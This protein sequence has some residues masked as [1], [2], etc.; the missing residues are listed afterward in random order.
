M[1]PH[2]KIILAYLSLTLVFTYPLAFNFTTAIPGD[3]YDGWQNYWNLWWVR[4]ALLDLHTTPFFTHDLFYP[5]GTSL[6]FHTLNIFNGLWTLPLQAWGNL[7][8]TYNSVVIFSFVLS[9]YGAYLLSAHVL[10]QLRE[11]GQAFYPLSLIPFTAG[12]IFAFAPFRFAHLLGHMQVFSTEWLPFF[13]LS[14]LQMQQRRGPLWRRA[15]LPS[16]FLALTALCDWY[17]ALY[18][19]LFCAIIVAY[20]LVSAIRSTL[21]VPNSITHYLLPITNFIAV[22]CWFILLVS[23]ILVPMLPEGTTAAYLR[24]PFEESVVLSADLLAFITPSEFHPLWGEAMREFSERFTTSTAERTVFAGFVPLLLMV[25]GVWR[26]WHYPAVRLWLSVLGVFFVL[27]LGPYLHIGGQI[28]SLF[29]LPYLWLYNLV[30]L[31]RI[32]RSIS[33]YDVMVMLALAVLAALGLYRLRV[34]RVMLWLVC[35]LIVFEFLAIPYPLTPVAV[36]SFYEQL[37]VE[38][39]MF[40][41]L[42]L[43]SNLDRPDPLV[44]Q[45]VH[46]RPLISAYTSR[47][48]PL[49]IVERTPILN[50]LRSL[51]P[52]IISYDTRALGASVLADLDV[53]YVIV[54]PLTMGAGDERTV[55]NRV[56]RELFGN[57]RPSV[58]EANLVV[59]RVNPPAI[60]QPYLVLGDSWSEAQRVNGKVSRTL[61]AD[62]P[63]SL[64]VMAHTTTTTVLTIVARTTTSSPL[65]DMPAS[66]RVSHDGITLGKFAITTNSMTITVPLSLQAQPL[67]LELIAN[68]PLAVETLSL[69]TQ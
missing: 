48:N 51:E 69:Q 11:K 28:V 17:F 59:Y 27:A 2:L 25:M 12:F 26:W 56:V 46:A 19:L 54:H 65:G 7:A 21:H 13:V 8:F 4:R 15:F 62:K 39:G 14:Y 52:D 40:S 47:F 16:L 32:T 36:P 33:R 43:P 1:R 67:T 66:L 31:V 38:E 5:T 3:G 53:R 58:N 64:R 57:Q 10:R 50:L 24:P 30:P 45:T 6:Y 18:L 49:S 29:P 42:E 35:G 23:P 37:R 44:Y 55:T 34:R 68:Q 22:I 63:A 41:L 9:A 61:L 20:Q 60:H